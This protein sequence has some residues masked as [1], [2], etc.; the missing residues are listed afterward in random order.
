MAACLLISRYTDSLAI[1]L[2]SKS[3]ITTSTCVDFNFHDLDSVEIDFDEMD[4]A[5]VANVKQAVRTTAAPLFRKKKTGRSLSATGG[6]LITGGN[7]PSLFPLRL[8][9]Y[10]NLNLILAL[11]SRTT[12]VIEGG[13]RVE[14]ENA[15]N[16]SEIYQLLVKGNVQPPLRLFDKKI[17]FGLC[18]V[19]E[20]KV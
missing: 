2:Q 1:A 8:P 14:V 11:N 12:G 18:A 16:E 5:E 9:P 13:I 7:L 17:D 4:N 15:T 3:A 10:Q 20:H 19:H 6:G